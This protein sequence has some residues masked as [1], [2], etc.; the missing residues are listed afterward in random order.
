MSADTHCEPS[1]SLGTG[2]LPVPNIGIGSTSVNIPSGGLGSSNIRGVVVFFCG[3]GQTGEI[4]MQLPTDVPGFYYGGTFMNSLVADG[5]IFLAV[6]YQET[7]Y[8]NA[9][10]EVGTAN[11]IANDSGFG[12]RYL[13]SALHTWDHII[14]YIQQTYGIPASKVVPFGWSWGAMR[15]LVIAA[16]RPVLAYVAH[17]PATILSNVP[18]SATTPV[19]FTVLNTS[20]YQISA[21][22]LNAVTV[23][24][25]VGY[26]TN[27]TTVG[28]QNPGGSLPTS[29][30]DAMIT[31]AVAASQPV[32]RN[33]TT[34]TH[35]FI[36]AD[37]TY[38]AG[39]FTS[40]IDPLAPKQF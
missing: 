12:S 28:W 35:E 15:T 9:S 31:A 8:N 37:A 2:E 40:T 34:D 13:A 36:L 21:T 24:G 30:T 26:G 16:N 4:P 27:D 32:T 6:P 19:N 1:G 5:W 22:Y 39:Y 7:F 33:A 23:P 29:N 17:E 25:V 14:Y 11:D 20:G 18:A 3:F 38:Y 10:V